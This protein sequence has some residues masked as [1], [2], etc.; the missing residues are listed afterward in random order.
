MVP[1]SARGAIAWRTAF[2]TSGWSRR[3]GTG[4][5]SR[6]GSTVVDHAQ[7]VAEAHALDA[8]VAAQ[9][10]ELVGE[11]RGLALEAESA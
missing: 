11:R 5:R 1:P 9:E 4:A 7:A 8:E 10:R 3:L 2:S 6:P